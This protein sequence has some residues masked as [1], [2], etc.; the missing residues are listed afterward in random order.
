MKP[1]RTTRPYEH[2]KNREY[3]D[4]SN[5]TPTLDPTVKLVKALAKRDEIVLISRA[6]RFQGQM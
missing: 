5:V 3:T 4:E 2:P 6:L 1:I